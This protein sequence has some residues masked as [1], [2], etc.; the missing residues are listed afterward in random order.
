MFLEKILDKKKLSLKRAEELVPLIS[1]RDS[2]NDP[3]P[4]RDFQGSLKRNSGRALIGEIKRASPSRGLLSRVRSPEERAVT[5]EKGGAVALSVLTEEDYFLGS[6][7]D[8]SRAKGAVSMPVL[9]KD[10]IF[11]EYQVYESRFRGADALLLISSIL[12]KKELEYLLKTARSLGLA[13]LVEVHDGEDLKKALD[14]GADIIGINNR[15]LKTFQTSL[16][17]TLEL[18]PLIPS[19]L[20]VVSESGIRDH[21]DIKILREAGVDAFLIGEALMVSSSPE[22]KIKELMGD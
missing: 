16:E 10:F 5:Y 9:R 17:V 12:S 18:M 7:E 11:S 2:L 15:D 1:I 6:L 8:L 4:L 22:E 13:S 3:P 19:N 14:C 21:E 20:L